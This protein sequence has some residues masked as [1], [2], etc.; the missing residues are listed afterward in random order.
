MNYQ[1]TMLQQELKATS[2]RLKYQKRLSE[3]RTLNKHFAKNPKLVYRQMKGDYNSAKDIPPKEDVESYWKELWSKQVMH[4]DKAAWLETLRQ[5]YCTNVRQNQ[6]TIDGQILSKVVSK[7]QNGKAPGND[8]IVGYWYKHLMFYRKALIYLF[9]NTYNGRQ[10]LPS[11]L[12]RARTQLIPKSAETHLA[13]NY[14]PIACQNLMFKMYTGCINVFLQDHCEVNNI[15]TTE[16]AGG[17]RDVWGCVEQLLINKTVLS[18]V[19]NNRRNLVTIWL[20]YQKAFD[21]V[22][23][24]WIIE[25]LRLA[26]V[27]RIMIDAIDSLTKTWTTKGTVCQFSCLFCH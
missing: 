21:S 2:E 24:S 11:W 17:K 4:N 22:P 1:K 3:R 5:D 26:K 8:L 6:Y 9:D 20:D 12:T 25:S 14:R 27:P 13:K 15:I 7:M 16:Q 10:Q 18:E 23:H 19:K